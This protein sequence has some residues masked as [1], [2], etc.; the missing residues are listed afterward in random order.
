MWATGG[1]SLPT[2]ATSYHPHPAQAA[3]GG[4]GVALSSPGGILL[5]SSAFL[6]PKRK[7][8][9]GPALASWGL[10]SRETGVGHG[11]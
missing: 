6:A 1:P 10:G 2:L 7:E 8:G 9:R 4:Q 11:S 5:A 3:A